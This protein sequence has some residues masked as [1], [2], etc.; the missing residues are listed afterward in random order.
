MTVVRV[1]S[2]PDRLEKLQFLDVRTELRV[3]GIPTARLTL[4]VP[5]NALEELSKEREIALCQPGKWLSVG[6]KNE[7]E[8][9]EFFSGIITTSDLTLSRERSE[10]ALTLKHSL[11]KLDSV[12]RSQVFTDITDAEIVKSLCQLR[13]PIDIDKDAQMN[14]RYEQRIQFR[15]TDWQML[16]QC[17]DANGAWLIAEPSRVKIFRPGLSLQPDHT[18]RPNKS[19]PMEIAHWQFS[20]SDQPKELCLRSWDIATQ[21]DL[22][23]DAKTV[24]LGNEALD[25]QG[26][27]T[28]SK[29]KWE[30]GYGTSPSRDVLQQKANSMLQQLQ[31]RRVQGEFTVKG[32]LEYQPGQTL[33]VSGYGEYFDGTGIITAVL[34]SI[35]PSRWTTTLVLGERG[36][37]PVAPVQQSGFL[38]GVV[39][40]EPGEGHQRFDRIRVRLNTLGDRQNEVWARFAMPYASKEGSFLCYPE[41]DDEVVVGFFDNDPDYPVIVGSMHNPKTMSAAQMSQGN[42]KKGW[43]FHSQDLRLLVDTGPV[44]KGETGIEIMG[45]KINLTK[46]KGL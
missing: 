16:R 46:P 43:L 45:P 9:I 5:G 11:V 18:L 34:H 23:V 12:V 1:F 17:L 38:P 15:C 24:S 22:S 20:A 39:V 44:D 36:L 2:G 14:T 40:R 33:K 21:T 32:T 3:N 41:F 27:D 37:I 26:G 6:I 7:R 19:Q 28:L 42:Y 8:T 13:V 10:L 25:P 29:M 30:L 31:L 4:S 35:T